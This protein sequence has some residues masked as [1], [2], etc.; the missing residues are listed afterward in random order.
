MSRPK[1]AVRVRKPGL[2]DLI[3]LREAARLTCWSHTTLWRYCTR[4]KGPHKLEFLQVGRT[5]LTTRRALAAFI[6]QCRQPTSAAAKREFRQRLR[7]KG[8]A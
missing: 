4:G 5:M 3:T 1:S 6:D 8:L 7:D 2:D